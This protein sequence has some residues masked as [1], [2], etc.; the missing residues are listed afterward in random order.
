MFAANMVDVAESTVKPADAIVVGAKTSLKP[1][2]FNVGVRREIWVYLLGVVLI[3]SAIEWLT[4]HR[5]ITV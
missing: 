5:R 1:S 4:Y 2:T 3:V